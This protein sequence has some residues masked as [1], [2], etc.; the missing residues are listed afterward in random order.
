VIDALKL[1]G[2]DYMVDEAAAEEL[3]ESGMKISKMKADVIITVGGDGT[4]L[5]R[6]GDG[7]A[8]PRRER[9]GARLPD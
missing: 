9:R 6:S 1:K 3:G 7:Q 2:V 4:I 5:G 8:H